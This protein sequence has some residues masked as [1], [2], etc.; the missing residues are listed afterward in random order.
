MKRGVLLLAALVL[1]QL[2]LGFDS[3]GA[4]M[5][6]GYLAAGTTLVSGG[7]YIAVWGRRFV[8]NEAGK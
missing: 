1:A 4:D 5:A 6:L 8:G 2:G 7:A 3:H